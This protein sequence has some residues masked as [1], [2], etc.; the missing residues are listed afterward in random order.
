[1]QMGWSS[2]VLSCPPPSNFCA[3]GTMHF[4]LSRN[5][6]KRANIGVSLV[7]GCALFVLDQR[8]SVWPLLDQTVLGKI[9]RHCKFLVRQ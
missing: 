2:S 8:T 7:L 6:G 5:V 1:M 9:Q 3:T 4:K